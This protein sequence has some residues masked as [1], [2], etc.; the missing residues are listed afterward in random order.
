VS[1]VFNILQQFRLGWFA[2][3]KVSQAAGTSIKA[4][5][6][7]GLCLRELVVPAYIRSAISTLRLATVKRKP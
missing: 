6:C 7:Q 5:N 4:L 2:F 3:S 1:S